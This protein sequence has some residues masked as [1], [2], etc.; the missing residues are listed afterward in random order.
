M[1]IALVT[2]A[3]GFIG[4]HC[5][6]LLLAKGYE[7]H[8]VSS[9]IASNKTDKI[10]WHQVDLLDPKQ[11]SDLIAEVK[12][13]HLLHL[14]WYAVPQKYWT[15]IENLKWVQ[16]S[17][18]LLQCFSM[19]KGRRVVI[20]GTCAEYDWRYGYCSEHITPF[21]PTTLYGSCKHSLQNILAIFSKQS[22]L[23]AAWG[24]I[25]FLYGPHEHSDR[26]VPSVIL[27]LLNNQRARCTHGNQIRDLLYVEDV[28]DAFVE[29]L[30]SDVS[31]AVNIASGFPIALKEVIQKIAEKMDRKDLIQLGALPAPPG[32]PPLLVANVS[33][34]NNELGWHPRFTLDQG[35][36]QTIAWWENDSKQRL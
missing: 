11:T 29:L 1:K 35:I 24:I 27:S 22:G 34:L 21:S 19:N 9:R 18:N 2:G 23:S 16:A 26:L 31:G 12:P 20:A 4:R 33:R 17:L 25:F 6:P 10:H 28:A 7:V 13:S 5:L 30:G 3:N 32:E 15:S 14:A 36:E 8:A